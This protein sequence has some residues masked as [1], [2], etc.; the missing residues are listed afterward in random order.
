VQ[1]G[2]R[3]ALGLRLR[4]G[5]FLA[6]TDDVRS[7]LVVVVDDIFARQYFGSS[8]PVGRRIN[9]ADFDAPARIVGVV[10]HVRQWGLV[11]D[12]AQKLRAQLYLSWAQLPDPTIASIGASGTVAIRTRIAP[13]SLAPAIRSVLQTR[14]GQV[15]YG[16]RSMEEIVSDSVAARKYSMA[17]LGSF[18]A[19]ALLLSAIGIYGV[20]SFAAGQRRGEIGVRMAL[21]AEPAD[22][23]RLIVGQG[24]RLAAAGI[25]A[26]ILGS[27]AL[28]RTLSSLLFGVSA[29]D[30]I[31]FAAM[32][33]LLG[34]VAMLACSVP[35]IGAAR[36][37]PSAALRFE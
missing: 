28:T 12:D 10:S 8:D 24:G 23:L 4:R 35:A 18:A 13:T 9:L 5:R 22:I 19:L 6:E 27:F 32:P 2:Y 26:G 25:A 31:T 16:F 11:A 17:L 7:P 21:G 34:A 14:N 33:V 3:Q 1:P 37:D 29:L 15:A 20:I 30:P 36:L